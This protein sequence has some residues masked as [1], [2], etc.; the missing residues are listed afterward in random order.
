MPT[1]PT[2]SISIAALD[3]ADGSGVT[4]LDDLEPIRQTKLRST[5]TGKN[6][7][8]STMT[9]WI[10]KGIKTPDGR[11]VK[12]RAV[13]VGWA[14]Y[15]SRPWLNEFFAATTGTDVAVST[16]QRSPAERHRAAAGARKQLARL[17]VGA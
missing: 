9:R 4:E 17:G 8:P 16:M 12:L 14:W 15:T 10:L 11:R 2:D 13:R 3:S 7:H 6:V 5:R 1:T